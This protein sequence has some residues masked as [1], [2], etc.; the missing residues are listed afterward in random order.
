MSF[1]IEDDDLLGKCD[2]VWNS[3]LN[4]IFYLG[5]LWHSEA[6]CIIGLGKL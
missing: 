5:S 3:I 2:S 1:P 6:L 4:M